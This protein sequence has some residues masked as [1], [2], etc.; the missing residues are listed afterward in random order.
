MGGSEIY[1]SREAADS[2]RTGGVLPRGGGP[3]SSLRLVLLLLQKVGS[4]AQRLAEERYVLEIVL[5][6]EAVDAPERHLRLAKEI[7]AA[8][9]GFMFNFARHQTWIHRVFADGEGEDF[10]ER[11]LA[12]VEF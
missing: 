8:A 6:P 2:G 5:E 7:R 10:L 9:H 11:Y 12:P 1:A 3:E 4:P